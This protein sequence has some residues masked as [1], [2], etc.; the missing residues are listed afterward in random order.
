M[1]V[2]LLLVGSHGL[3]R[4]VEIEVLLELIGGDSR[5]DI[6]VFNGGRHCEIVGGR[7]FELYVSLSKCVEWIIL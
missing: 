6:Q 4:T 3:I 2:H 1:L 5:V 7:Y